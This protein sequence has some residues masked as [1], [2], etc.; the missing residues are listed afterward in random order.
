MSHLT[1]GRETNTQSV[2]C[3]ISWCQGMLQGRAQARPEAQNT[4]SLTRFPNGFL[5]PCRVG[6]QFRQRPLQLQAGS[7]QKRGLTVNRAVELLSCLLP[8]CPEGGSKPV[9]GSV[10]FLFL[11]RILCCQAGVMSFHGGFGY[12]FN[13]EKHVKLEWGK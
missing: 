12:G 6:H 10:G 2:S 5:F 3:K 9:P 4:T 1:A 11:R 8:N 7:V 13:Y